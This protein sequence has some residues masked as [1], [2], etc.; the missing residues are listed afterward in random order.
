MRAPGQSGLD[1][2]KGMG[3]DDKFPIRK[4]LSAACSGLGLVAGHVG[5]GS[6]HFKIY[7]WVVKIYLYLFWPFPRTRGGRNGWMASDGIG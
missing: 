5:R 2:L 4:A 3:L 6:L 1:G 7:K